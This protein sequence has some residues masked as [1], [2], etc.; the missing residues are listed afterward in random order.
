PSRVGDGSNEPL[1]LAATALSRTLEELSDAALLALQCI[2]HA[3]RVVD[4]EPAAE[5]IERGPPHRRRL[6]VRIARVRRIARRLLWLPRA[7][8]RLRRGARARLTARGRSLRARIGAS[9]LALPG[10]RLLTGLRR[11]AR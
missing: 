5:L 4:R 3:Q 9:G 2:E 6:I 7:R 11:P 10:S 1:V 8:A